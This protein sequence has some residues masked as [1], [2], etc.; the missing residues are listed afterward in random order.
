MSWFYDKDHIGE[1]AYVDVM[2]ALVLLL[3]TGNRQ[4]ISH[5]CKVAH[6]LPRDYYQCR[7]VALLHDAVEDGFSS[8]EEIRMVCGCRV[9]D[10]V[11]VLT[12]NKDD[13]DETYLA[14]IGRVARR[15][16]SS[17]QLVKQMDLR[18]NIRRC[19]LYKERTG[20]EHSLMARYRQAADVLGIGW[21]V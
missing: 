1:V 17:A 4:Q 12:R 3:N 11:A 15:G 8:L 7:A 2:S 9:R 14:Y 10:D 21:S 18:E 16:S 5:A 6:L 19:A 13:K 20:N